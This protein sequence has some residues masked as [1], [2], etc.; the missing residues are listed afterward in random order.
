MSAWM[1]MEDNFSWHFCHKDAEKLREKWCFI[2]RGFRLHENQIKTKW[3]I[4]HHSQPNIKSFFLIKRLLSGI[5]DS[6]FFCSL[7]DLLW[8]DRDGYRL[9]ILDHSMSNYRPFSLPPSPKVLSP[10]LPTAR[11]VRTPHAACSLPMHLLRGHDA[12]G[13]PPNLTSH[14]SWIRQ[15]SS[16]ACC[17]DPS[18]FHL[19]TAILCFLCYKKA[20]LSLNG[21]VREECGD[22][23]TSYSTRSVWSDMHHFH[24]HSI[25]KIYGAIQMQGELGNVVPVPPKCK[26]SWEMSTGFQAT[27]WCC[28]PLLACHHVYSSI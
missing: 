8:P 26:G 7:S 22:L 10:S 3:K 4:A 21:Q 28:G 2:W 17:R 12:E 9:G 1:W 27:M 19:M 25:G 5:L 11:P 6:C 15:L 23:R 13:W 24:P 20:S 18:C 16:K 14:P